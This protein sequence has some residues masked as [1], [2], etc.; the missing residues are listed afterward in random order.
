MLL[1]FPAANN[2]EV[3]LKTTYDAVVVGSGAGGGMAARVLTAHGLK[4]LLLEAGPRPG[5]EQDSA[6]DAMAVRS[7]TPR[8]NASRVSRVEE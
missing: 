1:Q 7:S 3:D 8:Q 4:I 2:S 6:F 5:R